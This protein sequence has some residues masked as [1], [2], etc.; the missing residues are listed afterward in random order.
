LNFLFAAE[1]MTG[2]DAHKILSIP[3]DQIVE[4]MKKYNKT[5][6]T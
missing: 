1:T 6:M 2:R 4:I 5:S 3:I